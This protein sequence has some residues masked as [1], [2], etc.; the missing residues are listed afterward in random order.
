MVDE[1][2]QASLERIRSDIEALAGFN[3][4]PGQGCTRFSYG[5]ADKQA[6]AWLLERFAALNLQVAVDPVG[7]IRARRNGTQ[8]GAPAVLSGSH[9]DTVL[10]GGRF[11]G[12]VGVV[13]ALEA[14]R[15]LVE[16]DMETSHPVEVI[17]FAEEEGSN[18]GST[19]A[20]SKALTGKLDVDAIRLLRADNG[21][22]MYDMT[23]A[24]GF[25]PDRLPWAV[26]KAGTVK[27]MLE[28]HI[29]QSVVLEMEQVPIGIVASIY[30]SIC[31]RV[32]FRGVPNHAGAT[33]MQLRHDPMVAAAA[34]I[35]ALPDIVQ[36]HAFA[37]TVATVGRIS[38]QP[39]VINCIP[40]IVTFT[41]DIRDVHPDG[42]SSTVHEVE[43]LVAVLEERH[44]LEASVERLAESPVISLPTWII[45]SIEHVAV[46]Q[47][48]RYRRI[49]SGAV[50]DAAM[51][52]DITAV[53]MIFLP[54]RAGRS[55]VPEEWTDYGFITQGCN[56][57]LGTILKLAE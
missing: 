16:H 8:A 20:G 13:C 22:S 39:N 41:I 35:A 27:A 32:E 6:R 31:L 42:M 26:L 28:V 52:A 38:C 2:L 15:L 50:H 48:I 33:P 49:D 36:R 4:T 46:E 45:G 12:A 7:N 40:G 10:H 18:F 1:M 53:G 29:E 51:L 3:D 47:G 34:L 5:M 44:G 25:D 21:Q 14:M 30:G 23:K 24:A 11:D 43:R 56:L 55:H 17:V 19:M 57:L 9:L 54:S 37:T